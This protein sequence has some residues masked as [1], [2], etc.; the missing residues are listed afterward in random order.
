[1]SKRP[2]GGRVRGRK[3]ETDEPA[4]DGTVQRVQEEPEG[5]PAEAE[6]R[7]EDPEVDRHRDRRSDCSRSCRGAGDH[8]GQR[9]HQIGPGP[10]AVR[11]YRVRRQRCGGGSGI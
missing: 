7:A 2:P 6:T 4:E 11:A 9:D 8:R 5:D 1:M 3:E 10:T